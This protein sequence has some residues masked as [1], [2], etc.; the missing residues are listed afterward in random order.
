MCWI[1]RY[2]VSLGSDLS[3]ILLKKSGVL[4]WTLPCE[5]NGT[6]FNIY[7]VTFHADFGSVI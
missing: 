1:F 5:Q 2:E 3:L 4:K 6:L 7:H